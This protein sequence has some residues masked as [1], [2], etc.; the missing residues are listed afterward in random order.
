MLKI[1]KG[2]IRSL[3]TIFHILSETPNP[4]S[5]ICGLKSFFLPPLALS[6]NCQ[7]F[8]DSCLRRQRTLLVNALN[9]VVD[10]LF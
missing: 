7:V 2:L 9:V 10:V 1:K 3:Y 5:R 8:I 4:K 6:A